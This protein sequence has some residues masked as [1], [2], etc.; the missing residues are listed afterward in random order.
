MPPHTPLART[1]INLGVLDQWKAMASVLQSDT[2]AHES[3]AV[4]GADNLI[5]AVLYLLGNDD[6]EQE[7]G[8]AI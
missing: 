8:K 1:A 4:S 6:Y 3:V 7:S 5:P 2:G